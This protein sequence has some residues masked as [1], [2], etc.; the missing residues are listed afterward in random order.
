MANVSRPMQAVPQL[1]L[2]SSEQ[3]IGEPLS[4]GLESVRQD[5][6]RW[7]MNGLPEPPQGF[8]PSADNMQPTAEENIRNLL[9]LM[10]GRQPS[11]PK[12]PEEIRRLRRPMDPLQ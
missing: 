10:R 3:D 5:R 9:Q 6:E 1:L 4:A 7:D 12:P 2:D 8:V 11:R